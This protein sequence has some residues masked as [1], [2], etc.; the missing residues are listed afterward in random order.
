MCGDT[1]TDVFNSFAFLT[2]TNAQ[3]HHLNFGSQK[4]QLQDYLL[5]NPN[6]PP[7]IDLHFVTSYKKSAPCKHYKDITWA[8]PDMISK[9]H[10]LQ[11]TARIRCRCT[12]LC[13]ERTSH[14]NLLCIPKIQLGEQWRWR[15]T[16]IQ[17]QV[18]NFRIKNACN[19]HIYSDLPP[20]FTVSTRSSSS[21]TTI[22]RGIEPIPRVC[23]LS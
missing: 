4:Y 11:V 13:K 17:F 15:I 20:A 9:E 16:E 10:K 14:H 3:F 22:E 8:L 7:F 19:L 6:C 12:P 23:M 1:S 5:H 18:R 2:V 21:T